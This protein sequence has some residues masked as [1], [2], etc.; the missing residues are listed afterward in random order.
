[1]P[2]PTGPMLSA[3]GTQ[4]VGVASLVTPERSSVFPFIGER[5][6]KGNLFKFTLKTQVYIWDV[7]DP[8]PSIIRSLLPQKTGGQ[9]EAW[10][11]C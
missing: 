6:A 11:V 3:S 2:V 8:R 10:P 9:R 1:M 5:M 7:P 4:G